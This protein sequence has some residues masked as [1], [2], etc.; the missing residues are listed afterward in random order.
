MM[1]L[2][3]AGN[4]VHFAAKPD[5]HITADVRMARHPRD[6]T[7]QQLVA[8]IRVVAA[9]ALVRK[10]NHAIDVGKIAFEIAGSE[11]IGHITGNRCGAVHAR[12]NSDI[13][14]CSSSAA[15]TGVTVKSVSIPLQRRQFGHLLAKPVVPTDRFQ[16]DVVRVHPIAGLNILLRKADDLAV[17]QQLLAGVDRRQGN[18]VPSRNGLPQLNATVTH[19]Y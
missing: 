15:G 19:S 11:V 8:V 14:A 5:Q 17:L 7:L 18:L 16:H 4:L 13:I 1:L 9:P 12:K 3:Q 10:G 2:H 6:D